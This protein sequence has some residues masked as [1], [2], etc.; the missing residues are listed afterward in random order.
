MQIEA[1]FDPASSTISYLVFDERTAQCAIIDS[2]LDFDPKSGHT[3]TTS[4]DR[5]IRRVR[6]LQ[7][8]LQWI[9]ETHVHADHLSAAAYLKAAL[10]GQVAIGS[11]VTAVQDVFGKLFNEGS[12]FARDGSQFDRLLED[13][14]AFAIGS[15]NV[16]VLHTPGHTS[17]CVTYVISDEA[18]T[19]AFVGDVL[20]MPDYG[21]ARCDFP[22][23]NPRTLYRSIKR[24]LGLPAATRL[25]TCHDYRP[26]GRELRYVCTVAETRENNIHVGIGISEDEFVTMRKTRDAGLET[27]ALLLPSIQVNMCAGRLPAPEG[28]GT[29][30]LKIPINAF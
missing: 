20:F 22:G 9:L 27:P 15:L 30:Y 25:Y 29:R 18:E 26:G 11:R 23:G 12:S 7:A 6:E 8:S 28:N 5:L 10:G 17:A 4:A 2:V 19:A 13:E 1:F 14:E 24:I 16:R 3:G 21:T